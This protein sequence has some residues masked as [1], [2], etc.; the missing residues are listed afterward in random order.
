[1]KP[2]W[3]NLWRHDWTQ[4]K[5]SG[6]DSMKLMQSKALLVTRGRE[7]AEK[8]RKD[9][10]QTISGNTSRQRWRGEAGEIKQTILRT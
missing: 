2:D 9:L 10:L 5:G 6:L 7:T 3:I 8:Y 1:M 4:W